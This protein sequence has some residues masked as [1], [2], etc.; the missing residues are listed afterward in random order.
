MRNTSQPEK[1]KRNPAQI[2]HKTGTKLGQPPG[3]IHDEKVQQKPIKTT[4]N[5]Q[6]PQK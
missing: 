4:E 2:R 5:V 3:G 1:T 6:N